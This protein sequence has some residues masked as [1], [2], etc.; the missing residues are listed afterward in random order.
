[1]ARRGRSVFCSCACLM[2]RY[3]TQERSEVVA[4]TI[5]HVEKWFHR[6]HH[7]EKR[8]ERAK[9][10]PFVYFRADTAP[11]HIHLVLASEL[12]KSGVRSAW[13]DENPKCH[14]LCPKIP[15]RS[16]FSEPCFTVSA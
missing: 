3:E 14:M 6:C 7:V 12:A 8:R 13:P 11:D 10:H 1:M 2:R 5:R 9:Q 15:T 16:L 4:P